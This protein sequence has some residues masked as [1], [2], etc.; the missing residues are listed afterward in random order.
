[1]NILSKGNIFLQNYIFLTFKTSLFEHFA[2]T[3][4]TMFTVLS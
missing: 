3:K 4:Y 1:M 2:M